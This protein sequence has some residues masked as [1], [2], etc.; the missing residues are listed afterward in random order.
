MAQGIGLR[1]IKADAKA[2]RTDILHFTAEKENRLCAGCEN[3][4]G[5]QTVDKEQIFNKENLLLIYS[6]DGKYAGCEK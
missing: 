2:D 4:S 6:L 5:A 3:A 1:S